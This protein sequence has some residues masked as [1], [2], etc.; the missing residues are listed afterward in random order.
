MGFVK[1][2]F[3]RARRCVDLTEDLPR[4][5]TD[6]LCE[7]NEVRHSRATK[8][9]PVVRGASSWRACSRSPWRPATIL[10]EPTQARLDEAWRIASTDWP[11]AG[12]D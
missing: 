8:E 3:F 5:L 6:W 2:A 12:S 1:R 4:Q 9:P 11:S 7:V 10:A